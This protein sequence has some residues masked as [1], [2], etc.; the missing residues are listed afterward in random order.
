[1]PLKR[2]SRSLEEEAEEDLLFVNALLLQKVL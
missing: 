2:F 1:M